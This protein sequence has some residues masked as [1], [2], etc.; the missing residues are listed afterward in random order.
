MTTLHK[1]T[2]NHQGVTVQVEFD[3]QVYQP[4]PLTWAL[5][6]LMEVRSGDRVID[7]GCGTGY[8][9]LVAALLGAGEVICTDPVDEA[10]QW[11]RHNARLNDLSNL[12]VRQ[13]GG[14]DPV[15]GE[16]AD[17][18]FTLPPQMP[19]P[20]NFNPWRYGGID[21]SDVILQILRQAVPILA[22][23]NGSLYLIHSAW[24]IRPGC[25][26]RSNDSA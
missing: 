11:T 8:I 22:P 17:M 1:V 12:S 19:F 18:I 13:G 20:F 3:D 2:G 10:L 4:G 15:A 24:P 23:R 6:D 25:A 14:L 16:E 7:V 26:R 21:G 5:C 9:G